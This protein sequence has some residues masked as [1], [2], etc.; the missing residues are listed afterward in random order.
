VIDPDILDA[1]RK[2]ESI[3]VLTG[4]GISAESGVPTFRDAQGGLWA[5]YDPHD[6]ATPQAYQR[7]P[8]L[9]WEWYEGRRKL[10][11]QTPLSPIVDHQICGPAGIVLPLLV[12]ST[13]NKG[14]F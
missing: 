3:T 8:K 9:V 4:S 7:N 5:K 12:E 14:N 1:I 2:A 11:A 10:I 6:L 13:F